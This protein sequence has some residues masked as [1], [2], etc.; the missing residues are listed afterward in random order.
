MDLDHGQTFR[1]GDPQRM[2]K[3]LSSFPSQCREGIAMGL[4]CNLKGIGQTSTVVVCG[5]GGSAMAADLISAYLSPQLTVPL[6][7]VRGY[8]L[9]NY[10]G[11][12]SLVIASS[13]SGNTEETLAAFADASSRGAKRLCMCS[14]GALA[15][16]AREAAVEVIPLPVGYPPRCTV[17]YS[18]FA[19]LTVT[20]RLG[21]A[22]YRRDHLDECEEVL[23]DLVPLY[24]SLNPTDSNEAKRLARALEGKLPVVYAPAAPL[25]PVAYRWQTQLNENSKVLAHH[26]TLPEMNHNEIVGWQHPKPLLKST[27]ILFLRHKTEGEKLARRAEVSASLLRE[28]GFEV[29]EVWAKGHGSLAA[30]FSLL[31][32]GDWASYYLALLNGTDPTPVARID[33]LKEALS[34]PA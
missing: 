21:F 20:E 27:R 8:Q 13:Y 2:Q 4:R 10:V 30:M 7:V 12:N 26:G 16:A 19:L 6:T 24:E 3:I 18:F 17:G 1:S 31:Y 15:E 25:G 22:A 11:S 34:S 23:N 5:M 29:E 32:L 33:R 14:G 9:P 28:A